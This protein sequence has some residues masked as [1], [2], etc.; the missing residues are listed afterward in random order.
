MSPVSLEEELIPIQTDKLMP[1]VL[2]GYTDGS[3]FSL[4][5][6][7]PPGDRQRPAAQHRRF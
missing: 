2:L 3:L 5:L 4:D 1:V 6:A 7:H